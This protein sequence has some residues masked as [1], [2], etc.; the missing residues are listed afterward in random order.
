MESMKI[1][2]L[3]DLRRR[4][5][6]VVGHSPGRNLDLGSIP[7]SV[8]LKPTLQR[9]AWNYPRRHY[10]QTN[11]PTSGLVAIRWGIVPRPD[12]GRLV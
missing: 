7:G 1:D 6:K 8:L 9:L 2:D 4:V 10:S 11:S 12:V 5:G 3:G